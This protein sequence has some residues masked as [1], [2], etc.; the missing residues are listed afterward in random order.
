MPDQS[1]TYVVLIR[2]GLF[3]RT[4]E[5]PGDILQR[6]AFAGRIVYNSAGKFYETTDHFSDFVTRLREQEGLHVSVDGS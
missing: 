1:K 3:S 2:W 6:F 5:V 4:L